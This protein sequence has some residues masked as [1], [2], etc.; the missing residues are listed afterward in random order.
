[1]ALFFCKIEVSKRLLLINCWNTFK[2]VC[3]HNNLNYLASII[4]IS[5]F[6]CASIFIKT[7]NI[8]QATLT[9]NQPEYIV[10]LPG[11]IERIHPVPN[12]VSA[13]LDDSLVMYFAPS[14]DTRRINQE[15]LVLIGSQTGKL[16]VTY[17]APADS[18][19]IV[20]KPM[21]FLKP[22]EL[23]HVF[24]YTSNISLPQESVYPPQ[25]YFSFTAKAAPTTPE[26][27]K[28]ITVNNR[29]SSVKTLYPAD[30]NSDNLVDIIT[31]NQVGNRD[32]FY[33][34]NVEPS[35]EPRFER[36]TI[37]DDISSISFIAGHD[38]DLNK[39]ID[40][41]AA[42]KNGRVSLSL[43]CD[44]LGIPE[45][46]D[47]DTVPQGT[48][49]QSLDLDGDRNQDFVLGTASGEIFIY[50]NELTSLADDT[51][52]FKKFELN[53]E[54][55]Q[56][57][58]LVLADL[59][60]DFLPDILGG[61]FAGNSNT[62]SLS[63]FENVS[64]PD[65]GLEFKEHIIDNTLRR[66]SSLQACDID[67][68]GKLDVLASS[69]LS[70]ELIWYRNLGDRF[71][72]AQTIA[73]DLRE[74]SFVLAADLDGDKDLDI[75]GASQADNLIKWY[76][77]DL[78]LNDR[79]SSG[80][81]VSDNAGGV[82]A[83]LA[84]DWDNDGDLDLTSAN[85]DQAFEDSKGELAIYINNPFPNPSITGQDIV[86]GG[87]LTDNYF[88]STKIPGHSFNWTINPPNAGQI[89]G[90]PDSNAVQVQWK[91]TIPLDNGTPSIQLRLKQTDTSASCSDSPM[92]IDEKD[93][94]LHDIYLP[95]S[96]SPNGDKRNDRFRIRSRTKEKI[97]M[98]R[99]I[100]FDRFHNKI[101]EENDPER[102]TTM[103]WDGGTF[104][105]GRYF[106]E[107]LVAFENCSEKI[108]RLGTFTLIR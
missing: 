49:I 53:I 36:I 46:I 35:C 91:K 72:Q 44:D 38:V 12:A 70:N 43:C 14:I 56:V 37:L 77:N 69:E 63:W 76:K 54:A 15:D 42:S 29:P 7:E 5:V 66:V 95:S 92:I 33:F 3:W 50:Y 39:R 51:A 21:N 71:G 30:I 23:I 65:G 100:V 84:F 93:I 18:N 98:V 75:V 4:G 87:V 86:C 45:N 13:E 27:N 104:P 79:F 96:F 55:R 68:D 31:A 89:I 105:P 90:N 17:T 10:D 61:Y 83:V 88:S 85:E 60:G 64:L 28:K 47:I 9:I 34:K 24:F 101:F 57:E 59:N 106:F 48:T 99:F 25:V 52:N 108:S 74:A 67:G 26:F 62:K 11:F 32:L 58:S 107:V 82:E 94:I 22:G 81:L 97:V 102:A 80:M 41:L 2:I 16:E 1:M 19:F 40:I 73:D 78:D 20:V 6:L 103:G 8:H